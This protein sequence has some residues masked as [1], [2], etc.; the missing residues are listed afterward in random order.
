MQLCKMTRKPVAPRDPQLSLLK[1]TLIAWGHQGNGG[2]LWVFC[3]AA[4]QMRSKH[5]AVC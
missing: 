2:G 3:A 1:G 5:T 4:W